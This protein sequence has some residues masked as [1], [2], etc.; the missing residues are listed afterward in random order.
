[1]GESAPQIFGLPPFTGPSWKGTIGPEVTARAAK[2]LTWA[3]WA[4][5]MALMAGGVVLIV[6]NAAT[7]DPVNS[8]LYALL[9]FAGL[10]YGTVGGLIARRHS[11]NPIGWLFCL[12]ALAFA[13]F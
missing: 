12:S 5:T 4:L 10:L 3:A 6:L 7:L 2:T 8:I 9:F 11:R 13:A 1:M